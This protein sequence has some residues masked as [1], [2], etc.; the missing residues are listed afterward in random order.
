MRKLVWLAAAA[1]LA[2]L[3]TGAVQAQQAETP[4]KGGTL[5]MTAPYAASFGSLDPHVT[6][7]AQDDIVGKAINRTL[8]N[9]NT[10]ANK[11]ELELAKSVVGVGRRPDLYLQAAR[12]RLLPQRPQDDGRRPDLLVHPHH[13]RLQG[14]SRRALRP[15]DQGRGRRREGPGQ[16]DLRPEEDRRL[17]AR[18][19][20]HGSGRPRLLLLRRLDGDPAQGRGREGQLRLQPGRPRPLQV[21]GAHPGFARRHWSASTS[22]TSPASPISTSSRC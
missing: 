5:R 20:D 1:A 4:R 22:S 16:G 19:D 21:Q 9:W 6:P 13:G 3:A 15:P 8:Y 2:V 12:R 10:A 17:H 18:D 7:R 14:L 11:L